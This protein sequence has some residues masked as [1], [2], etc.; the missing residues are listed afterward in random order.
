M[1]GVT[2]PGLCCSSIFTCVIDAAFESSTTPKDS[3][4]AS[5]R[6]CCRSARQSASYNSGR[7]RISRGSISLQGRAISKRLGNE[8][9]RLKGRKG[10]ARAKETRGAKSLGITCETTGARM[11]GRGGDS[12]EE[13]RWEREEEE[14]NGG[15]I[16]SEQ[17]PPLPGGRNLG[18]LNL[19]TPPRLPTKRQGTSRGRC[20]HRC[21]SLSSSRQAA[22]T[23]T[24]A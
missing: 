17:Q 12:T 13:R 16:K 2:S 4:V 23:H 6:G 14:E 8:R 5:E 15:K 20:Q 24:R 7:A 3:P 22:R 11:R 18:R 1:L 19:R 9:Y 21:V 10:R